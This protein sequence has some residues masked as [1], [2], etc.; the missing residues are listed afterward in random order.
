MVGNLINEAIGTP[1][2]AGQAGALVSLLVLGLLVPMLLYVRS[3]VRDR[4][5]RS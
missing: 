5:V 2:Q 4:D 3:T 1:G